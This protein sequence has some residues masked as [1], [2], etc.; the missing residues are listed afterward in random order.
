MSAHE[1]LQTHRQGHTLDR[2]S[3]LR[4]ESADLIA[5]SVQAM[6]AN[7]QANGAFIASPDF[8]QYHY[9]WL[10]D[11]SFV[12][13]ALD[14]VGEVEAS[15]RYHDWVVMAIEGMAP[16]MDAA[17]RRQRAGLPLDRAEMS[18]AR[19]SLG[20]LAVPDDWPN[21]QMDGY[22]IWLWSLHEHL[23]AAG[24][25]R[26]SD[27]LAPTVERMARYVASFALSPCFD[28]WEEDGLS[29]HTSTLACVYGGLIAAASMLDDAE[30]AARAEEVQGFVHALGRRQGRFEKSSAS[31]QVDASLLWLSQP[32]GLVGPSDPAFVQTV[33]EV[34]EKLEFEG[35]L[36]RYPSDTYYGGGVWPLLNASL[37]WHYAS[38]GD[39]TTARYH[40][41]WIAEHFDEEG[42][43]AEQFGG[44]RRDPVMYREW[45][46]RWGPP[47]RELL[48][49]HAMFVVLADTVARAAGGIGGDEE[50][51]D[52]QLG[53]YERST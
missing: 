44:E 35:G 28:V 40:L 19:F 47:A 46:A 1:R 36:R 18:P 32:F 9:C 7:Q 30:I 26:L 16:V 38:V 52:L 42:H 20:G 14:R 21:F 53:T 10:R 17:V 3:A 48:W 2:G 15:A 34:A 37:G 31:R 22:G 45:E 50:P 6:L 49:S 13:Y 8:H 27:R 12:A 51:N 33:S 5:T 11:A 25:E 24:S 43:L 29:V 39:L 41:E 4:R 23:A